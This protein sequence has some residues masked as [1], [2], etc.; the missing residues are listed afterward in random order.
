MI[1]DLLTELM[2]V[3]GLSGYEDR[4]ARAIAA[5]LDRMELAH[6]SDRLGNLICTLPGDP[7]LPSVMVFAH[8]DQL[9]FVVRKIEPSGLIRLERLGGVP[10]RALPAQ[11]V[12]L[13]TEEGDVPGVISNKSHHATAPDEKYRVVPITELAVDAGFASK[14]AAETA[15]V[16]IGTPVTYL[17]RVL[18]LS[19]GRIAGTS[20][21]D[22]AGCAALLA[23]AEAR[24]G[25]AGPTVHLVWSVQEEYNL[26]GVLPTATALA[27]DIA[28]SIDTMLACDTPEVDARGDVELGGGPTISLYSF[29]GRGTLNGVIPHPA[30]VKLLEDAAHSEGQPLQRSAHT[31]LLTDLSY[32][33]FMGAQG[34]A[35]L[36]VGVPVRYS[37]SALEVVDPEDIASL[38][39]LLDAALGRI[40]ADLQLIRAPN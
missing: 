17:P 16:R 4:V 15:G 19:G 29:H 30:L 22:R 39:T 1:R 25:K 2:L 21:D 31:G 35:C 36:D 5:R 14:D 40:S 11:A 20:V 12:L 26:R 28:L 18:E 9:G 13:C 34:V 7:D 23:L 27:P 3:P 10:E 24:K 32:I 6:T 33:G 8:M 38:V 37:H